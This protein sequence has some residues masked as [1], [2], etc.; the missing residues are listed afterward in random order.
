MW[1]FDAKDSVGGWGAIAA[2]VD[3]GGK[4][5]NGFVGLS[6][7]GEFDVPKG[8]VL[9]EGEVGA[10]S[11]RVAPRSW[12]GC[13]PCPGSAALVE[14]VSIKADAF[15]ATLCFLISLNARMLPGFR[16]HAFRLQVKTWSLRSSSGNC[17]G[18]S[19]FSERRSDMRLLQALHFANDAGGVD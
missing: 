8:F 11:N 1:S 6:D 18:R 13:E 5:A 4:G 15:L 14:T 10:T 16:L 9:A 3:V 19:P 7:G 17:E 12:A 2:S